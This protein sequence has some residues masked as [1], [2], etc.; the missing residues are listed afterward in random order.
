MPSATPAASSPKG[1]ASPKRPPGLSSPPLFQ[2][3]PA[4]TPV[5]SCQLFMSQPSPAAPFTPKNLLPESP[6]PVR[7]R[8]GTKLPSHGA[9]L[10]AELQPGP[11]LA[12]S[13]AGGGSPGFPPRRRRSRGGKLEG[14]GAL[15]ALR[16]PPLAK[17]PEPRMET[18]SLLESC[19]GVALG[20]N[21]PPCSGAAAENL[22]RGR[23]FRSR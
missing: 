2:Q 23:S 10:A 7:T 5:R 20:V 13:T 9:A 12:R 22:V 21:V 3:R 18:R 4:L 14:S 6:A 19:A 8:T 15:P 16:T 11:Q 1:S 17:W